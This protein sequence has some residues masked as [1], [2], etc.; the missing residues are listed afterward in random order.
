VRREVVEAPRVVDQVKRASWNILSQ[1]VQLKVDNTVRRRAAVGFLDG[2]YSDIDPD[3]RKPRVSQPPTVAP[4]PTADV[5][6]RQGLR[7]GTEVTKEATLRPKKEVC[8]G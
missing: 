5:E 6:R 2:V 8:V 1:E 4:Q 3:H 7:L